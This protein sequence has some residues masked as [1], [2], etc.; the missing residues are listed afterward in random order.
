MQF[1][2]FNVPKSLIILLIAVFGYCS[3]AMSQGLTDKYA[4]FDIG[5]SS[6]SL[7]MNASNYSLGFTENSIREIDYA[8]GE[9]IE[10]TASFL[11]LYLGVKFGKYKGLSHSLYFEAGFGDHA[12]GKFGYSLGYNY[13]IAIGRFDLLIRPSL[14]ITTGSSSY[15][16]GEF[17]VDTVG[18]IIDDTD[19]I[20]TDVNVYVEQ[21][22]LFLVPKLEVTFLIE[23]K[24]GIYANVSFDYGLNNKEQILKF[25]PGSNSEAETLEY[26]LTDPSYVDLQFDDQI[27]DGNLFD[28][29]TMVF[30]IGISSYFNRD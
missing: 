13:P 16:L 21:S 8:F 10:S 3:P 30:S 9:D 7:S 12:K 27:I 19:I 28:A 23:Q 26:S 1:T 5:L 24:V 17:V 25:R 20:D 29:S 6:S 14:G 18:V 22:N 2:T 4:T 11:A 15:T